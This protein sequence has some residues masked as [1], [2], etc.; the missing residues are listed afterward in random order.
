MNPI[1]HLDHDDVSEEGV[2]EAT[3]VIVIVGTIFV[4]VAFFL[5]PTFDAALPKFFALIWMTIAWGMM[6]CY[7]VSLLMAVVAILYVVAAMGFD[8]L[9]GWMDGN[10]EFWWLKIFVSS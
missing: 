7:P 9:P 6:K 5:S 2:Q 3:N 8:T 1:K 10:T 4:A